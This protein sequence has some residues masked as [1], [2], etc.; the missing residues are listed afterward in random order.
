MK[1]TKKDRAQLESILQAA[2]EGL[3]FLD[4]QRVVVMVESRA[5]ST[6]QFTAPYYP[7]E[8]YAKI[9]KSYGSPLCRLY[10]ATHE[11]EKLLHSPNAPTGD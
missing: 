7:G 4:S 5:T 11:L 6:D 8:Q 1:T 2:K 9:Q 10:T 3:A